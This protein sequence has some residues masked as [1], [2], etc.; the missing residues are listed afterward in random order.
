[1]LLRDRRRVHL[2]QL[3]EHEAHKLEGSAIVLTVQAE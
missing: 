3:A 2:A 1:V